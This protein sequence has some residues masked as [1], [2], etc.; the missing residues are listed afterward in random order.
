MK[1]LLTVVADSARVDV[2]VIDRQDLNYLSDTDLRQGN[3]YERIVYTK[4]A[5][6]PC[7]EQDLNFII[8][9]FVKW[10]HHKVDV[11][12]AMFARNKIAKRLTE[13]R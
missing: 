8:D 7:H 4:E 9:Q 10:D 5:D 3:V 11:V 12:E 6:R 1:S 2:W 13:G